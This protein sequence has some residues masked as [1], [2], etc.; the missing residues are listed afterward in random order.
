ME[1]PNLINVHSILKK[2]RSLLE[3]NSRSDPF[4]FAVEGVMLLGRKIII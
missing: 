1:S 4:G 3:D 2:T